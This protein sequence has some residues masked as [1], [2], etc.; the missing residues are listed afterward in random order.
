MKSH[1][2][3]FKKL[4]M[5]F[6][7]LSNYCCACTVLCYCLIT[8]YLLYRC[9][10][11]IKQMLLVIQSNVYLEQNSQVLAIEPAF[12]LTIEGSIHGIVLQKAWSF[13]FCKLFSSSYCL[14]FL[15]IKANDL[16]LDKI[17]FPYIK[18]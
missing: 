7:T 8:G 9:V 3:F 1:Y 6:I 11:L 14:E 16:K 17:F 5:H 13:T 15:H 12:S 10:T 18:T 2:I 4:T